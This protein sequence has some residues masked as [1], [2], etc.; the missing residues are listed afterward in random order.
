MLQKPRIEVILGRACLRGLRAEFGKGGSKMRKVS[1]GILGV[2]GFA[3]LFTVACGATDLGITTKVKS[4]LT[5][6]RTL[7]SSQIQVDTKNK[8]VTLSGP[9]DSTESK[10]KA[11]ALARGVDGVMDVVD[12]LSV[13]TAVAAMPKAAAGTNAAPD[14]SA[15]TQAVKRNLQAQ[16]ETA[17][18]PINVQTEGGVVTLTGVVKTPQ[19]KDQVVQIARGTDGV[20]RVEDKI[21]VG[22]S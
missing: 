3:A 13:S 9:V 5:T 6:E 14:D 22:T 11:V 21:Q 12:N 10:E 8:V 18:E 17:Q 20:Q 7:N 4:R 2:L 15:I 16:P 1:L 19:E